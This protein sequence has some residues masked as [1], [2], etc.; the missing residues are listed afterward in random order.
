MTND[1]LKA[2]LQGSEGSELLVSAPEI[3]I[4]MTA[5]GCLRTLQETMEGRKAGTLTDKQFFRQFNEMLVEL[6]ETADA[7]HR[8]GVLLPALLESHYKKRAKQ[9][10]DRLVKVDFSPSFWRWYNWWDD[11]IRSLTAA[12]TRHLYHLA[13]ERVPTVEEHRPI[14]DWMSHR[15]EPILILTD[16]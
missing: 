1:E 15:A 5:F 4:W 12:Q 2:N 6:G 16:T 7:T 10:E 8:F 9:L 14:G 13:M 11:Y 3:C